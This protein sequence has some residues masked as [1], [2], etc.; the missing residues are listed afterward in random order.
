[1]SNHDRKNAGRFGSCLEHGAAHQHDHLRWT[2]R[3]F[4]L[5]LSAAGATLFL[6]KTPVQAFSQTPLLRALSELETDR[7]LVLIQMNGG[8]DGLNTIVPIESDV[9][10]TNRPALAIEKSDTI[11]LTDD[12][13]MHPSLSPLEPMFGDGKMSVVT[14]VGYES[15][16]LSHFR[17][18]DI[19]T[20]AS[21]SDD[22]VGTGWLGRMLDTSNPDFET[23]PPA[24]PLAVQIGGG[25]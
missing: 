18:T 16:N 13:G 20:S 25:S 22:V 3:D 6:G 4:V 14:N 12:L 9:Y 8:N 5:G 24:H 21:D 1:M 19:W 7:V 2:R 17:S 15:P 23:S 11:G 10:Y